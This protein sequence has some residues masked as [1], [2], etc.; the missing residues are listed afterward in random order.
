[1]HAPTH[2]KCNKLHAN[3][4]ESLADWHAFFALKNLMV[5]GCWDA[6]IKS[7]QKEVVDYLLRVWV[8]RY[9]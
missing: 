4:G 9:S 6:Y 5:V 8:N 2:A 7:R 1:M 3:P